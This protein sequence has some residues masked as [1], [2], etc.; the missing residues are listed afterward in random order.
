MC[1]DRPAYVLYSLTGWYS[2]GLFL[3]ELISM[4]K[5]CEI[6]VNPKTLILPNLSSDFIEIMGSIVPQAKPPEDSSL[7]KPVDFLWGTKIP[8][9]DGVKL[10][11]TIF[12]PHEQKDP[13]PVIFTLTPYIAD[14]YVERGLYFSKNGYVFA[15]V[16]VRGRGN[17]EGKF[18]PLANEARDGYDIVEWIAKQA[19]CDGNIT[20]WGGSNA[21][22]NQ[23]STAKEFPS[24]LRTIV[25]AAAAYP[26]IDFPF[27]HNIFY[28]YII[29]WLTFT[30]GVT[31]NSNLFEKTEFWISKFT[32][33]QSQHLAFKELDRIA[34][35]TTTH[36]QKW[37][38]HPTPDSYWNAMTPT[39]E[40]YRRL[41]IPILTITGHHDVDQPGAMTYYRRHMQYGTE[42]AKAK[43]YLIIGPWDH[44]GTR[45]PKKEFGGLSF[46]E[47]SVLD[48]NRLHK[49]WYDWTMKGRTKPEF[50]KKRIAY[51]VPGAE[52]W[53]YAD[54][55]ETVSN[56]TLKFYLG[57][58]DGQPNEA[59]RSGDLLS[60][61]PI[62]DET[63]DRYVYD[64]LDTR[65]FAMQQK[66][67]KNFITDQT[68]VLNL[69]GNG[70]VYHSEAFEEDTEIT[71]YAKLVAFI[72]IDVPDTDFYAELDEIKPDGSSI[73]LTSDLKRTRYR[74]SL[75]EEKLVKPGE[76][77][78]YE[79][80]G[81]TFFSR[82][83]GK[84][85]RLR[86]VITCP[87]TIYLQKNYNSGKNVCL[88]SG[89]DARTA[90]VTLYHDAEHP[91]FLELPIVK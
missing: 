8:M 67:I 39:A 64:P 69:F 6:L 85:S 36:F 61:E 72:E 55:L 2:T 46:G 40:D 27:F 50:L 84:G 19:W 23:W 12:K 58:R 22:F 82:R 37:L 71:G 3:E 75:V 63:P 21:G 53:K 49:E 35:N 73:M 56:A 14:S 34:G 41:N 9:R 32:E 62:S 86:L 45:T 26:G 38:E 52:L 18:E 13:L 1:V 5:S 89:K 10:D 30:S 68:F 65:P 20:M 31:G 70:L 80:D 78:R 83:I 66:E 48:L 43:H 7:E 24:H 44:P 77:I 33:Y 17:S 47:T 16:D 81:F 90:H 91:S 25:P 74:D 54:S 42:E 11:A 57:S 79:F 87:N 29:Q 51:Y 76:M 60:R 28:P 59:F 88:E 15:L 4:L